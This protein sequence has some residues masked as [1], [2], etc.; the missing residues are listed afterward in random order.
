MTNPPSAATRAT[1]PT[2]MDLLRD[3]LLNKGT[4]FTERERDPLGLRGL[5]PAVVHTQEE[6]ATRVM[7]HLRTLSD[8]LEKYVALNALHDR[9]EALFFRVV[10]DHIDEVMPIIYTPTVGSRVPEVRPGLP[11][12]ARA[13]SSASRTAAAWPRCCATGRTPRR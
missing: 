8:P 10:I 13:F 4:A 1:T 3:P 2:G 7:M 11:A 12:P 6:Q 9:N 5:L